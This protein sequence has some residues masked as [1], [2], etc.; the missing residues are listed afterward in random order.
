MV[1]GIRRGVKLDVNYAAV[2]LARA[3][4]ELGLEPYL[5]EEGKDGDG[6]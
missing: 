2:I 3:V 6:V 5:A 4:A 1:D